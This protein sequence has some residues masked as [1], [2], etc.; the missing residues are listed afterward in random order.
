MDRLHASRL[1]PRAGLP[2][3]LLLL[4]IVA[5]LQTSHQAGDYRKFVAAMEEVTHILDLQ[6][7]VLLLCPIRDFHGETSARCDACPL[8][9][10]LL[11][12]GGAWVHVHATLLPHRALWTF[13]SV[14]LKGKVSASCID[15]ILDDHAAMGLVHG[16][17]V[18]S[19]IRDDCRSLVLVDIHFP[20]VCLFQ[21]QPK[22]PPLLLVS[23]EELRM[24]PVWQGTSPPNVASGL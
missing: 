3:G 11:G 24:S 1:V 2:R 21:P 16:A 13:Q 8:L 20:S 18:L 7:L 14:D 5:P 15:S 22:P 19:A 12:S 6:E 17:W 10:H 23:S 9:A 4:S